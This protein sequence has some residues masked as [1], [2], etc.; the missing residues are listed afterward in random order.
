MTPRSCCSSAASQSPLARLW[1]PAVRALPWRRELG[2]WFVVTAI[3]HA[4]LILDRWVV[5]DMGRRLGSEFIPQLGRIARLGPGFGLANLLGLLAVAW[6]LI[7]GAASWDRAVALLGPGAWKWLHHGAHV[8]FISLSCT[9]R[10]SSSSTSPRRSTGSRR[11]RTGSAGRCS[12]WVPVCCSSNGP[13]SQLPCA[14]GDGHPVT[15]SAMDVWPSSP[16]TPWHPAAREPARRRA[17]PGSAQ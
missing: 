2:I 13:P 9:P 7:L 4:V 11:R 15:L 6:A 5:W 3:V 10:T 14:V 8:S 17:A 1:P 12:D 16:L